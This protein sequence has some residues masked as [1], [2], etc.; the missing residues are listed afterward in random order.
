MCAKWA[1]LLVVMNLMVAGMFAGH[2]PMVCAWV[3]PDPGQ[4]VQPPPD[5]DPDIPPPL[6]PPPVPGPLPAPLPVP[7]PDDDPPPVDPP[8]PVD[9]PPGHTCK[10]T[11]HETP[12]PAGFILALVGSGLLGAAA[13]RRRF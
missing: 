12:E 7:P 3:P 8:P 4:V 10:C 11:C 1:K 2:L 6:P 5:P 13:L 9:D